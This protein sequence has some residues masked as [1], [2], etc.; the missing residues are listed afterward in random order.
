MRD[1]LFVREAVSDTGIMR[2]G[3]LKAADSPWIKGIWVGRSETTNE[4]IVL[5]E[6][7]TRTT[8]TVRRLPEGRQYQVEVLRSCLGVPWDSLAGVR[9]SKP[10]KQPLPAAMSLWLSVQSRSSHLWQQQLK[11]H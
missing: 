1:G 5:T 3:R 8:R 4:H 6:K 2:G 10:K 11:F 7:G 9:A